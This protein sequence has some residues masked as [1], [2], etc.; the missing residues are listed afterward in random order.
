MRQSFLKHGERRVHRGYAAIT[1]IS[2]GGQGLFTELA[3]PQ[4]LCAVPQ[5]P[6]KNSKCPLGPKGRLRSS[7]EQDLPI[8]VFSVSSVVKKGG[9]SSYVKSRNDLKF[10]ATASIVSSHRFRCSLP[11]LPLFTPRRGWS[12]LPELPTSVYM[13]PLRKPCPAHF[14]VNICIFATKVLPLH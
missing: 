1:E 10:P 12:V 6:L 8:S 5:A 7:S 11:P 14:V 3:A 2:R 9:L 4:A 13:S